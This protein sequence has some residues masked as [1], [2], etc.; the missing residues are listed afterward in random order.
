MS[1][2]KPK[3][4]LR[5]SLIGPLEGDTELPNGVTA[6]IT[7]EDDEPIV[8]SLSS[9]YRSNPVTVEVS[10]GRIVIVLRVP[11]GRR[12]KYVVVAQPGELKEIKFGV[13][14]E[15][16]TGNNSPFF[17]SLE[18]PSD[19]QKPPRTNFDPNTIEQWRP[20]TKPRDPWGTIDNSGRGWG[21]GS[22]PAFGGP[23]RRESREIPASS[24]MSQI[25]AVQIILEERFDV[26]RLTRYRFTQNRIPDA[27]H[28][29]DSSTQQLQFSACNCLGIVVQPAAPF[30]EKVLLHRAP[31]TS[32][33]VNFRIKLRNDGSHIPFDSDIITSD[34]CIT[35]LLEFLANGDPISAAAQARRFA[36]TAGDYLRNKFS[37][38]HLAAVGAYALYLL[39]QTDTHR[40]W[41]FNLYDNFS[42]ISDG[43][44]LWALHTM[45]SRPGAIAEWYDETRTALIAAAAR[46][47]PILTMGVRMLV[48]G[49]ERLS[50]SRRSEGDVELARA[51]VRAQWL[52][53]RVRY[54]E[55]FTALWLDE[56]E[57]QEALLPLDWSAVIAQ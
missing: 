41:L 11:A 30:H 40:N 12:G 2:E 6:W 23:P 18:L 49:L 3:A 1:E 9:G 37:N 13:P 20:E 5:L 39:G 33:S 19:R 21:G 4:T 22:A 48:E 54:D 47:L 10:P 43:A 42:D 32:D 31:Q 26:L 35:P 38:H 55:T 44:I 51:L 7:T 28:S 17:E 57:L 15:P 29:I 27:I 52:Q 56:R 53:A 45:R 8:V 34:D 24:W 14:L 16:N 50:S 46:P 25:N 36:D